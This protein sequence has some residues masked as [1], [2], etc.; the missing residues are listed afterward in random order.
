M[1]EYVCTGNCMYKDEPDVNAIDGKSNCGIHA[2]ALAYCIITLILPLIGF[3][4][5]L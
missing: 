5:V 1:Y 2:D 4:C 3:I